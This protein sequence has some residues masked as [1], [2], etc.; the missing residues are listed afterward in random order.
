MAYSETIPEL[1][2]LSEA[3][4]ELLERYVRGDIA[5]VLGDS[6]RARPIAKRDSDGPAPLSFAQQQVWVHSQISPDLPIYNEPFTVRRTGALDVAALERVLTEII[7][8]HEAW[9]TVFPEVNGQ[10]V[11]VVQAAPDSFTLPQFD[12]R[13]LGV[14][15]RAAEA[16]R[17]AAQDAQRP[18]DLAKGPLLRAKLVRLADQEYR[19]YLTLHQ[20]ILDGVTAYNVLLPELVALYEAFSNGKPSPLAELA[21]Q[22]ADYASWQRQ[23]LTEEKLAQ[24][25]GYWREQLAGDLPVLELPTDRPRPA[26]Q[27]FRGAMYPLQ[28]PKAV[29]E[30]VRGFAQRE[31]ATLFMGMLA[32]FYAVLHRYTGQDDILMGSLT[33]SRKG[34]GVDK[35]LGYFVNPV[36]L[37]A[38]FD[39]NPSFREL[40]GRVRQT[41]LDA[42]AH[43]DVPF[44][45]LVETLHPQRDLSRNPL[46]QIM[47]SLE[48]PMPPLNGWSMTQFDVGSGASKFDLYLDLDDREEGIIGPVTFNPDLF[49]EETIGRMVEHWQRL[50]EAA[51]ADPTC[52]ISQ[53]PLLAPSEQQQLLVEWND[54]ASAQPQLCSPALFEAQAERT[55][56]A[57]AV[58]DETSSLSYRELN[59]RA[60]QLA[61]Y[62]R[63][64]GVGPEKLVGICTS[65][66]QQMMVALL[67]V[68]KAGGAYVPLDPTYPQE[69]LA[70][71]LQ[72]SGI[73]VLITEQSL[74]AGLPPSSAHVLC[75]D[76]DEARLAE[77]SAENLPAQAQLENLAYVIYTSGSTGRPKGVQISHGALVNLLLSMQQEPGLRSDDRL[78]AVTTLSFD[79]AALELFLP[80]MTGARLV[81]ASAETA[82]DGARLNRRLQQAGIT[83]MQATPATWRLLLETG[84]QG[85]ANLRVWCG[86]EALSR[87]LAEQ[88][89]PRCESLWNMYGPTE[90]TIWSA[91]GRIESGTG[92][93]RIGL[94]VANTEFYVLDANLQLLP[95]G[96]PGELHIGGQGLARGYLHQA[97]LTQQKFIAHPFRTEAGRRLYKTGD[98]V[99]R[100][101][102]GRLEFLGRMDEQVKV[103]GFRIELGEIET[104]LAEH[105]AVK[106]AV[107]EA[108]VDGSKE[109]QL[110]AYVIAQG[111]VSAEE[112]RT[113]LSQRL[114]EYMVP[115]QFVFLTAFPLTP[116]GKVNR[117]A[118]PGPE[119]VVTVMAGQQIQPRDER[120]KKLAEIWE[121]VLGV[122]PIGIQQNF[123]DL[124][125]HSLLAA[126]IISQIEKTFG[127]RLSLAQIF[128]APTVEQLAALLRES[129]SRT[130]SKAITPRHDRGPAPLSH[131]EQQVWLHSLLAGDLPLYNEGMTLHWHGPLDASV[132]EKS[133][134][135]IVRR[136]AI[137]RTTFYAIDGQPVQEVHQPSPHVG[138]R[139]VDLR[140]TPGPER[141]RKA[142]ELASR[143]AQQPFDLLRGPLFRALLIRLDA[144]EY[145]L[146]LTLHHIVFDGLSIYNVFIPEL[147]ALYE[148]FSKG[149]PSPLAELSIQYSDYADWEQATQGLEKVAPQIAY[150]QNR[151]AGDPPILAL[152]ADRPRPA[153]QTFRGAMQ[154]LVL[155]AE[156]SQAIRALCQRRG[157][158]TYSLLLAGFKALL[159]RYSGQQDI[160]IGGIT[161]GR[162]RPELNELIG[163]FINIVVFRTDVSG[164]PT[165]DELL[166]RV[167]QT[168]VEAISHDEVPFELVVKEVHPKRDASRSP[169]VQVLFSLITPPVRASG[170]SLT[171]DLDIGVTKYDLHLE[172]E[173]RPDGISGCLLYSTDLFDGETIGRMVEHWQRLLEAAVADPTCRISQLPL[174]APS[175]QQQLLVEWNDTAS[176]QPQ[177]C[178][179]ALFE[180]Q[181]EHTPEAVAVEDETSSLSYRELNRRAN[182]LAQYLRSLGVGPEKLVGICTSR[183]QQMMVALLGVL[184]AGG[185]Y[186]PLD[187][188]YPQER[189]AFM[190]QDSGVEVLITEQSLLAGLPPSSAQTLC[191][192]RDEAMLAGQSA[193]NLPAQAQLGE[194]GV[195]DLHLGFDGAAQGSADFPWSAGQPAALDA[196]GTGSAE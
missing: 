26:T 155:S 7:R 84:W 71:M 46:F 105:A 182:Q 82:R 136:H 128:R 29:V 194:S 124:G 31:G 106:A 164:D 158:T 120:E 1:N 72:D 116:N 14:A 17:L 60:N 125:G 70:F 68:L 62:L 28:V 127:T 157:S 12:L 177:L 154:K 170:W 108:R 27:T 151:L 178:L 173:D 20:I 107:V 43:D 4:R 87:E 145:R 168:V 195:R 180:A 94:P 73:E 140:E 143:D 23:W 19:L 161:S 187:P 91:V 122:S 93:V 96:V 188:T 138:L 97:E 33:A 103:R 36:V 37:R 18:F 172:L 184:K 113:A 92:P 74:V 121:A 57:V 142:L 5:H 58:E 24:Q 135:E 98:L 153:L 78:L 126:K 132:L 34:E 141:E 133:L 42:L 21:F 183:S 148:A 159:H 75:L 186:V 64:L 175:E 193:D 185:A 150:W 95:L 152:P 50:L 56:E 189:L 49:D 88:L 166:A 67:G 79:I 101:K 9:R 54:T 69:R 165:F 114:P 2:S 30:R 11:Q 22:H 129:P 76:R 109:K 45:Y 53:L 134:T 104:A 110:V 52:R 191:L 39:G 163:Y 144:T 63:S 77:Q 131:G 10:P 137:L 65:R 80:L 6:D 123:F 100:L 174:L 66:S 25:L 118:L 147:T 51:V 119:P 38:H 48:P 149:K 156:L 81:L 44:E 117:R 15:E 176:A 162:S 99:R 139:Q 112:L 16:L 47:L 146:Y 86:G 181:A 41:V 35:L 169:L 85:N 111:T 13:S 59:R 40:L 192:D 90:T 160:W 3:K 179:P 8:R 55:P 196:T 171:T 190:L 83:V 115:S 32:G 89:L 167:Q 61:Q 102:D 130:P